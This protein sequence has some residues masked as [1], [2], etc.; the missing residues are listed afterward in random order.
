M[1][2]LTFYSQNIF[3][4]W[5]GLGATPL[6]WGHERNSFT[7][8][9]EHHMGDSTQTNVLHFFQRRVSLKMMLIEQSSSQEKT[10]KHNLKYWNTLVQSL[11]Q[12]QWFGSLPKERKVGDRWAS[13]GSAFQRQ[14]V[15]TGKSLVSG[16][17]PPYFC[18]KSTK[19]RAWEEDCNWQPEQ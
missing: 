17:Y 3:C 6:I 1:Y 2:V 14:W 8:T 19:S 15:T 18:R 13:T 7:M 12:E 11:S 5:T 4:A 10:I 16:H 9:T